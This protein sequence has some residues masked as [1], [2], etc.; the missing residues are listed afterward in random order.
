MGNKVSVAS[1]QH[2]T[3]HTPVS[4][5]L[6][7]CECKSNAALWG[8]G[9]NLKV[10]AILPRYDFT[11]AQGRSVDTT[12]IKGSYLMVVHT[13][14]V[15]LR[16]MVWVWV[17]FNLMVGVHQWVHTYPDGVPP[18]HGVGVSGVYSDGV[19]Q[20]VHTLMVSLQWCGCEWCL[21]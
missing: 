17:V 2:I 4:V 9:G 19:H 6:V 12:W 21:L 15:S 1:H 11:S 20:W 13:L 18:M 14:M 8:W 3:I 5:T 10:G 7:V 16:C